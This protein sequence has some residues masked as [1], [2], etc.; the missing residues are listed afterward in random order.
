MYQFLTIGQ[1]K[2]RCLLAYGLNYVIIGLI[3]SDDR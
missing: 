2:L 3:L 1:L